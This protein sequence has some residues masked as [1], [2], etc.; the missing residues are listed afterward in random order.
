MNDHPDLDRFLDELASNAPTPGGGA[1][2][3]LVGAI[4]AELTHMVAALTIG[5]KK[6]AEH[7][8]AFQA[9]MPALE[10]SMR[11]L[12]GMMA[13]DAAA[14]DAVMAAYRLPRATEDEKAERSARIAAATRDAAEPPLA[15]L[16]LLGGLLPPTR[17]AA[18]Y[19]NAHA[20]SDAGIAAQLIDAAARAAALN[21]RINAVM[22]AGEDRSDLEARLAELLPGLLEEAR[23]IETVVLQRIG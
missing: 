1:V 21:V 5:K 12:R 13:R 19:G 4:A 7:E 14:F 18:E 22:L 17:L 16:R 20:V 15:T 10:T 11:E 6:Y 8:D 2:A 23:A 9:A 3:G